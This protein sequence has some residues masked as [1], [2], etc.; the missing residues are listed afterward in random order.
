MANRIVAVFARDDI[1]TFGVKQS[2][3]AIAI[4][5]LRFR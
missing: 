2:L 3:T 1:E 4:D 5:P